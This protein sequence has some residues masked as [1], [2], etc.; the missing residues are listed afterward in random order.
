MAKL[1]WMGSVTSAS[2]NELYRLVKKFDANAAKYSLG[3]IVAAE[4]SPSITYLDHFISYRGDKRKDKTVAIQ[5]SLTIP[6][7]FDEINSTNLKKFFFAADI[8]NA[9]AA[10]TAKRSAVMQS[11]SIPL[12]GTAVMVMSTDIGKDLMYVIPRCALKPNGT[13]PLSI[14]AW[15]Q[16]K[17]DIEV[18]HTMSYNASGGTTSAPYG[19][20]DVTQVATAAI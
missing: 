16:G 5:K 7:T 10:D 19:F 1:Y 8:T 14:D 3:D 18:L 6:F 2:T 11:Q 17:F 15:I 9:T 13:I 12:E 20:L 4:M